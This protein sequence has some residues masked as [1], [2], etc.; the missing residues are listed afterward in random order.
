MEIMSTTQ[1]YQI[2][3]NVPGVI[4]AKAKQTSN[5]HQ[6]CFDIPIYLMN[7]LQNSRLVM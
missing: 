4:R 2:W 7:I 3:P 1:K 6:I 5:L